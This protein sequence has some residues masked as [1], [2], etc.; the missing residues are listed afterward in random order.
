[1]KIEFSLPTKSFKPAIKVAKGL[2]IQK[3]Q[4][5]PMPGIRKG[6]NAIKKK[7]KQSG[8]AGVSVQRSGKT[9]NL[10]GSSRRRRGR[11]VSGGEAGT[12]AGGIRGRARRHR[13]GRV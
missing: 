11:Y 13:G 1:M 3:A 6:T 8:G 5:K 7:A 12:G 4:K 10:T 2:Q 9:L